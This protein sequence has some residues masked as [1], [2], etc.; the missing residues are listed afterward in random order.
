MPGRAGSASSPI[1]GLIER[2][3]RLGFKV[4]GLDDNHIVRMQI[5]FHDPIDI[6]EGQFFDVLNKL[7]FPGHGAIEV[8]VTL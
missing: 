5:L 3:L 6:I 2:L 4:A 8:E 7:S 1:V